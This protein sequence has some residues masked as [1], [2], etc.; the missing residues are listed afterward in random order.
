VWAIGVEAVDPTGGWAAAAGIERGGALL[1]RPDGVVA[2]R[3]AGP[4]E[5]PAAILRSVVGRVL[6]QG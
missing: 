1:V 4:E 2:W 3:S 6:V 5:S